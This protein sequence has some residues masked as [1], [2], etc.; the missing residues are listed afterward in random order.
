[1]ANNQRNESHSFMKNHI[2]RWL[3]EMMPPT[4]LGSHQTMLMDTT[5]CLAYQQ[6]INRI[7]QPNDIVVDVGT[8]TGILAFFA[9][10]AGAKRVY[11]VESSPIASVAEQLILQN[12]LQDQVV[13]IRG[14][15]PEIQI[16]DE[17]DVIVSETVGCWGIDENILATINEL[18]SRYGSET[19]KIIPENLQLY[20]VP[21]EHT[22]F[23]KR[24]E[25]WQNEIYGLDYSLLAEFAANN[26]YMR[27]PVNPIQFLAKPSLVSTLV[28]GKYYETSMQ[29]RTS[30]R[31]TKSGLYHGLAGWF[32]MKLGPRTWITTDP[33]AEILHWKQCIFPALKPIALAAGDRVI[34]EVVADAASDQVRFDWQTFFIKR[35]DRKAFAHYNQSTSKFWDMT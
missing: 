12:N 7:I 29:L 23:Y 13:L 19:T 5:R 22:Q 6:A 3:F 16:S 30:F 15:A 11:A 18:C 9:A 27:I 20:L 31:I 34:V 17:V 35:G 10:R 1:M 32:R 26:I 2:S 24:V 4:P 14:H 21:V 28:I 8:G 25:F 33:R